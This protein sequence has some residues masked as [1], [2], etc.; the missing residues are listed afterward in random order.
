MYNTKTKIIF[1]TSTLHAGGS[2]RVMALLAN[3]LCERGYD[4]EVVCVNKHIV[5]Y[6]LHESVQV[7]FAEDE[8]GKSY[9]KKTI[10][11]R[12]HIKEENP[13]IVI[14]FMLEVYC[15]TLF[16]TIGVK[17]PIISSERIDPHFFGRAKSFLRWLLLRRT[18]HLVVQTEQ[19][20]SFFSLKLQKRTTIIPNPVTNEVFDIVSNAEKEKRIVAVGRLAYQKNYPLMIHAFKS[21]SD[22]FPDYQLVI[23]GEGPQRDSLELIVDSLKL[24]GRV[25]LPGRTEHVIEEL[26][27]SKIFCMSS[28]YEGMSN[29][30]LEAVCIGLPVVTT[31]VS[32]ASD[33]VID[34][35]GGIIVEKGNISQF[36][37]AMRVLLE[38]EHLRGKMGTFNRERAYEF[39]EDRIVDEWEELIHNVIDVYKR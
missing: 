33:M 15:M 25:L 5:F 23:F 7:S 17:I 36:E 35:K 20:K 39:K 37:N 4:V 6:P 28:D 16:S 2:E 1:V 22:E 3:C 34:G 11:L 27:K 26:R 14:A 31:N 10:W 18:T 29:A 21:I 12:K 8:V 24:R 19:I 32:G 13:D 9:L 30:M 38:D